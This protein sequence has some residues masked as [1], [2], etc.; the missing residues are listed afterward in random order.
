ML[1]YALLLHDKLQQHD[2]AENYYKN[3]LSGSPSSDTKARVLCR[4]TSS[5]VLTIE[6]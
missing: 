1:R 5:K 6:T 3:I 2:K 4:H